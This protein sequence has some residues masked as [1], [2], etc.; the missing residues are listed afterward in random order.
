MP[1]ITRC[2][3]YGR[4]TRLRAAAIR[5]LG[6]VGARMT[7]H[8]AILE[9]LADVAAE[10]DLRIVISATAAMRAIGDPAAIAILEDAP[11]RHPDGRVRREA[12]AAVLRLRKSGGT[13]TEVAKLTDDLETLRTAQAALLQR[14]EKLEGAGS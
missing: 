8:D 9:T 12:K 1:A 14:V 5:A 2:C 6:T 4:P 7:H 3:A 10:T 13:S 11:A